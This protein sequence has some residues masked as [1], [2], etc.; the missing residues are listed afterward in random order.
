MLV[1]R[2]VSGKG[3][4]WVSLRCDDHVL[5]LPRLLLLPLGPG[6]P[7]AMRWDVDNNTYLLTKLLPYLILMEYTQ[8]SVPSWLYARE[9]YMW[10]MSQTQQS[11]VYGSVTRRRSMLATGDPEKGNHVTDLPHKWMTN[12]SAESRLHLKTNNGRLY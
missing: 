3:K 7:L 8:S 12:I 9:R 5:P 10:L 4:V 6:L 2:A 11:A 1:S